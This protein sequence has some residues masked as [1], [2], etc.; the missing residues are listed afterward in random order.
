MDPLAVCDAAALAAAAVAA[1]TVPPTHRWSFKALDV[2]WLRS[3]RADLRVIAE[4]DLLPALGEAADIPV[5][6]Q[7]SDA[8]GESVL[9]LTARIR[10]LRGAR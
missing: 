10:A 1:V 3:A 9:R 8:E 7:V 2:E 5:L 4:L 6:V